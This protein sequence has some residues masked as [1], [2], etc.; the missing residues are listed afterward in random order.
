[1]ILRIERDQKHNP[2]RT[3]PVPASRGRQEPGARCPNKTHRAEDRTFAPAF[4]TAAGNGRLGRATCWA[5][6][7]H[8]YPSLP[9]TIHHYVDLSENGSVHPRMATFHREKWENDEKSPWISGLSMAFRIFLPRPETETS[10]WGMLQR[11]A[12]KLPGLRRKSVAQER[13]LWPGD[14]WIG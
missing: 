3:L 4:W 2:Q 6:S 14:R 5:A 10:C 11:W 8:H 1:M 9:V 13:L 12:E 7:I